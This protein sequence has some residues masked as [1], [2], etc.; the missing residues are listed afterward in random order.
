MAAFF[1]ALWVSGVEVGGAWQQS[2]VLFACELGRV[3]SEPP[4]GVHWG[5]GVPCRLALTW[6]CHHGAMVLFPGHPV[7][8]RGIQHPSALR[9]A[10][11]LQVSPSAPQHPGVHAGWGL[12]GGMLWSCTGHVAGVWEQAEAVAEGGQGHQWGVGAVVGAVG[13]GAQKSP[14]SLRFSLMMMSVTASKTN[15]TFSVSVAQVMCE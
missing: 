5:G 2:E 6:G 15:L 7:V 8:P 14:Q 12:A 10:S 9:D 3:G 4:L 11:G 1:S 13:A